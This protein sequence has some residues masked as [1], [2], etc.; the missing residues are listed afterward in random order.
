MPRPGV[1]FQITP[2][3]MKNFRKGKSATTPLLNF[4]LI[5]NVYSRLNIMI[6]SFCVVLRVMKLN[7]ISVIVHKL[8]LIEP[9]SVKP[10]LFVLR[11]EGVVNSIL[12][13]KQDEFQFRLYF[14]ALVLPHTC[15]NTLLRVH[16]IPMRLKRSERIHHFYRSSQ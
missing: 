4:L 5:R 8:T 12:P 3:P 9:R 2:V 10:A 1:L 11:T 14:S 16:P 6:L 15:N 13:N 7:K